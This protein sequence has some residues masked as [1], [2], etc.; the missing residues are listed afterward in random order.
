[1][2]GRYTIN[3]LNEPTWRLKYRDP[4]RRLSLLW[5]VY[6]KDWKLDDAR[7][8]L[9]KIA[10]SVQ[11]VR[12]PDF[13][14]IADRPRREAEAKDRRVTATLDFLV[15]KGFPRLE[16]GKPAEHD[17]F[18]VE[19]RT[20]PERRLAVLKLVRSRPAGT[21]PEYLTVG[22]HRWAQAD[23][24]TDQMENND[25]YPSAGI[26]ALL[27]ERLAKPGPHWYVIRT[28]R[29]D[30]TAEEHFRLAD[31]LAFAARLQ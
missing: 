17:G 29:L 16:S 19:Y 23:G 24:W 1:M 25:Y 22:S 18:I 10:E 8:E 30:E 28:I 21:L 27:D 20:E 14:G 7:E 9:V 5:Q 15:S 12:E 6:Q 26:K 4:S 2:Q 11:R 3:G 13:A 31:F